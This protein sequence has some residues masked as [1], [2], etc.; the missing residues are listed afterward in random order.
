MINLKDSR[1]LSNTHFHWKAFPDTP[2]NSKI[3]I[4][5]NSTCKMSEIEF[6]ASPLT[7]STCTVITNL[8]EKVSLDYLTRFLP[9]YDQLAPE[10]ETK[11]GG[12]YNIE[13]YGNCARGETYLDRIKDEFNNQAT[14][15]FK[16]WGFRNTNIKIFANGKLQMTGPKYENEAAEIGKLLIDIIKHVKIGVHIGIDNFI[17]NQITNPSGSGNLTQNLRSMDFQLVYIPESKNVVYYRRDY[18]RFL[19]NYC[20]LDNATLDTIIKTHPKPVSRSDV[21]ILDGYYFNIANKMYEPGIHNC[22]KDTIELD[23]PD[24]NITILGHGWFSDTQVLNIINKIEL[25]KVIFSM[26]FK[27]LLND[28]KTLPELR[29]G[30]LALGKKY[31]DFDF[32]DLNA[33]LRNITENVYSADERSMIDVKNDIHTFEKMYMKVLNK[34]IYRMTMIRNIDVSICHTIT[35]YLNHIIQNS[36]SHQSD[37]PTISIQIGDKHINIPLEKIEIFAKRILAPNNYNITGTHTVM[38]NSD[39]SVGFNINLKKMT[40]ILKKKGV[41]NTYEPDEHSGVNV[42]YYYNTDNQQQGF[43]QCEPHCSTR[44]KRSICTKITVLIFRPGSII[45]TGSRNLEQLKAV[46]NLIL[47]ILKDNMRAIAIEDKPEDN[48][49]IALLNNEFR[50]VSRKPRLFYIKKQNIIIPEIQLE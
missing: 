18:S 9:V 28:S 2:G 44:E 32:R 26:E 40:K 1:P 4:E 14:I 17:E 49:H 41:F 20:N 24:T 42:R 29:D 6:K 30:I 48:K 36:D 11:H 13:Y 33:I 25:I 12:I 10:L 8:G 15:K 21:V 7:I 34:K 50:K 19:K 37:D 43:C 46:Y 23:L 45:I 47:E 27:K 3:I 5:L 22:F 35:Q 39:F 16:Y 31:I 38:I